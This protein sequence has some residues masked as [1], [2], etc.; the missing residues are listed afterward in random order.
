MLRLLIWSVDF[1]LLTHI[2][3]LLKAYRV[4]TI[5]QDTF[6]MLFDSLDFSSSNVDRG[7]SFT[8]DVQ[9]E[10]LKH[11]MQRFHLSEQTHDICVDGSPTKYVQGLAARFMLYCVEISIY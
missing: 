6:C 1:R 7:K 5:R 4:I 10:G 9:D 2:L 3:L 11:L 8:V